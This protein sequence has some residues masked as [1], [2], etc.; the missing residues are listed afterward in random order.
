MNLQQL[1]YLDQ[2]SGYALRE[3]EYISCSMAH[4]K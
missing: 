1:I 3:E 4:V 2:L